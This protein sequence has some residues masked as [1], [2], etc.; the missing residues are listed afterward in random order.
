M[1]Q[2]MREGAAKKH[3]DK[4]TLPQQY[5]RVKTLILVVYS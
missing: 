5:A 4:L 2:M 1:T 3:E